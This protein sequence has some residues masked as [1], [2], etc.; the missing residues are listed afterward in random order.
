M[1]TNKIIDPMKVAKLSE[2]E[3][4]KLYHAADLLCTG[5][6]YENFPHDIHAFAFMTMRKLGANVRCHT[7]MHITAIQLR[8]NKLLIDRLRTYGV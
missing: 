6:S 5:T 7:D 2:V 4:R 8:H 3:F 1:I